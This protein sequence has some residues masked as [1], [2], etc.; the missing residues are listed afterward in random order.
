MCR[1]PSPWHARHA[2]VDLGHH[3]R[4]ACDGRL[5]DVDADAEVQVAVAVGQRRLDEGHVDV[6]VAAVKEIGNLRQEDGRVVGQPAVH[7]RARG[8]AD[9]ERVV[10]HVGLEALVGVGRHAERPDV[11]DLG[12][13]EGL[14]IR[15]HVFGQRPDQVLRFATPGADEDPVAA[16]DAAE[17]LV[18]G[19]E[20]LR[21]PRLE[22]VECRCGHRR[23]ARA[24]HCSQKKL[25]QE[26]R[27]RRQKAG[28]GADARRWRY[29][30][31]TRPPTAARPR[32]SR[33]RSGRREC[34]ACR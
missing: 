20:L 23:S 25:E 27:S 3:E 19:R 14:G 2:G 24:A 21:V 33:C 1:K 30:A 17:D 18:R 29:I 9:E 31:N 34:G 13:E 26:D 8:V 5:H 28:P 16:P 22:L 11:Q 7:G 6:D 15:A 32:G 10:A 4:G 12:A